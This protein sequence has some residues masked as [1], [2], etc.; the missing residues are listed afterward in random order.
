MAFGRRDRSPHPPQRLGYALHRPRR[1]R[2]VA[3]ELEPALLSGDEPGEES[4]ER[5]RVAAV[6]RRVRRTQ[7]AETDAVDAKSVDVVLDHLD[8]ERTDGRDRRL[9]VRRAT[10]ARDARLPLADGA[11]EDGAVRD[12]LVAGHGDVSDESGDGLD[13]HGRRV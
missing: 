10:E 11:D 4:H 13:A 2:L 8:S 3:D 7:P 1:E 12:G 5:A 6:D 9:R